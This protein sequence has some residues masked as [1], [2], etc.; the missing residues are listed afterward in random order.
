MVRLDDKN[1]QFIV[2]ILLLIINLILFVEVITPRIN[3]GIGSNIVKYFYEFEDIKDLQ[4]RFDSLDK[5]VSDDL[6]KEYSLENDSRVISAYFKFQA[7]PSKVKI[8]KDDNIVVYRLVNDFISSNDTFVLY[9][10]LSGG[11][12]GYLREYKLTHIVYG[13]KGCL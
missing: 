10:G 5:L 7:S 2:F 4:V 11:V 3:N 9:Y 8:I 12:L 1:V 6:Y 13:N